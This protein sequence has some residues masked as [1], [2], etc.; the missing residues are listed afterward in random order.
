MEGVLKSL[1]AGIIAGF[2][3]IGVITAALD[4]R[5]FSDIE[6]HCRERGYIQ[7]TKTRINCSVE[8]Q[9]KPK[10]GVYRG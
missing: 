10:P 1:F 8:E 4:F 7:D 9:V 6:K 3:V 2:A 5:Y